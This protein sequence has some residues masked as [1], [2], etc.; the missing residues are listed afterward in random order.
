[1]SDESTI[2]SAGLLPDAQTAIAA[3]QRMEPAH[4]VES[5]DVRRQDMQDETW[6]GAIAAILDSDLT[7][8]T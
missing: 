7:I 6:D 2:L 5:I 1:L 3:G 8:N 4:R